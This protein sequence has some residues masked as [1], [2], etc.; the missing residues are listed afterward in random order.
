MNKE[1]LQ[2]VITQ[3]MAMKTWRKG[4]REKKALGSPLSDCSWEIV[5]VGK[6]HSVIH[7]N[8]G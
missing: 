1:T 7:K 8:N 2:Q 4:S 6:N 3:K 5:L